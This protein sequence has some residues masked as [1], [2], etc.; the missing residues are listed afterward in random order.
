[1]FAFGSFRVTYREE[2][3]REVHILPTLVEEFTPAQSRVEGGNDNWPQMRCCCLKQPFFFLHVYH[4]TLPPP[5]AFEPHSA[6]RVRKQKSLV[7]SP[8]QDVPQAFEVPVHG[9]IGELLSLVADPSILPDKILR[10]SSDWVFGE[11]REKH[12]QTV[13][14]P[15]LCP[16]V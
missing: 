5:F 8:E 7:D 11:K 13:E 16:C 14:V 4:R 9:R 10:D 12:L 1:M 15:S 2:P 6:Q 3:S